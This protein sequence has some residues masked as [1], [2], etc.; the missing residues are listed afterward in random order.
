MSESLGKK[1]QHPVET[2]LRDPTWPRLPGGYVVKAKA[3]VL[4]VKNSIQWVTDECRTENVNSVFRY[5]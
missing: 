1:Q 2:F 4:V 3:F 5:I